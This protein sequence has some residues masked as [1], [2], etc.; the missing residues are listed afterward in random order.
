MSRAWDHENKPCP[1]C[2]N[3]TLSMVG[4]RDS[5]W[6][7]CCPKKKGGCG[8]QTPRLPTQRETRDYWNTRMGTAA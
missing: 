5:G 1:F 6:R 2:G 4:F 8:L 7:L 3:T